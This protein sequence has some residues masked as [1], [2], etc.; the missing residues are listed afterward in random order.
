MKKILT[1]SAALM[2]CASMAMAQGIG[3]YIGSDCNPGATQNVTNACTANTGNAF[4]AVGTCVVPPAGKASFVGAI[5][6]IDIQT[7]LATIPDWWRADGCRSTGFGMAADGSIAG[8][9]N[10]V[11][12]LWDTAPPAGSNLSG[13]YDPTKP[14]RMRLLLGS[15]LLPN[16]VYDLPGDGATENMV[17]RLTVTRARTLGSPSCAG[18]AQGA[19][20]VLNE[21]QIQGQNDHSMDDYLRLYDAIAGHN[22]IVY[23]AG[24]PACAGATPAKNATWGSVKAL[25]R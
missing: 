25:Y 13:V 20:I 19:C 9:A 23:N 7:A 16:D 22:F 24:A 21:V 2:L 15:V 17:F 12:T 1:L 8:G 3:F 11:T 5:S 6:I 4:Q 10:C 14:E 18:C